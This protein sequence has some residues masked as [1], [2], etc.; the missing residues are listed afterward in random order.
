MGEIADGLINGDFDFHTGEYIGR[1]WGFP[2]TLDNSLPWEH[3][4]Q[5]RKSYNPST[6]VLNYMWQKGVKDRQEQYRLIALYAQFKKWDMSEPHSIDYLCQK[7]QEK[8]NDFCSWLGN[9]K[10]HPK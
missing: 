3:K 6:G 2:R 1:G 5:K 7:I 4:R 9:N 10:H 8:F